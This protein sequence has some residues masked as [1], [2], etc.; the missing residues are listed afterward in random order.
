MYICNVKLGC[1]FFLFLLASTCYAAEESDSLAFDRKKLLRTVKA[2][3]KEDNYSKV[4]ESLR[5]AFTTYPEACAD[6]RLVRME[7]DAQ[8]QLSLAENKKIFLN[9]KP[10]TAAYFACVL[11]TAQYA[12]RLD[13]LDNLPDEKGR[14][15]PQ[16]HKETGER[17]RACRRKMPSAGRYYYKQGDY[18]TAWTHLDLY[19][20]TRLNPLVSEE[21]EEEDP[22]PD[23]IALAR[24]ATVSAFSA[25]K[26]AESLRYVEMA[27]QD[28]AVLCQLLEMQARAHEQ[29]GQGEARLQAV[30]RGHER[31]PAHDYFALALIH[32]YDSAACYPQALDVIERTLAAGGDKRQYAFVGGRIYEATGALDSAALSYQEAIEGAPEDALARSAAGMLALRRAALLRESLTPV[33]LSAQD[34]KDQLADYYTQ[35]AQQLEKA[36]EQAPTQNELWRDGLREAYFRLN[37]GADLQAL[38]TP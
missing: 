28:T 11:A 36:R 33:Q 16:Y 21:K 30:R 22:A 38:E 17:L 5:Q 13:S 23:T 35:A 20:L 6:A 32:H 9:S 7:M 24:L 25:G 3:A 31:F 1:L 37:R 15:K 19:L 26:Y 18:A 27:E 2:Y 4:D 29:L 34:V 8:W 12:L 14:V 10:D